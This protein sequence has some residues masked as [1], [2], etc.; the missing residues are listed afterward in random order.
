M[1]VAVSQWR[2]RVSPVFDVAGSLLL[3]DVE[4]GRESNREEFHLDG[5]EA[6]QSRADMVARL[7]TNVLVCGA[8]SWPLE[9]ALKTAGVEVISQT[10]GDVDE[11]VA[12]LAGGRFTEDAFLMPG[13]CGR[14]RRSRGRLGWGEPISRP[15]KTEKG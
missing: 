5:L 7:G 4:E 14:R 8:I 6:V 12:A 15:E 11:I 2:G 9:V 1:K 10:C 13:C 3:V